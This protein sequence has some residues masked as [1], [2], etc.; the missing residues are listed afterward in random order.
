MRIWLASS[1]PNALTQTLPGAL[2]WKAG[3]QAED[4]ST[5]PGQSPYLSPLIQTRASNPR[6]EFQDGEQKPGSCL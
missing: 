5:A 4:K 1:G 2:L 6:S 3:E